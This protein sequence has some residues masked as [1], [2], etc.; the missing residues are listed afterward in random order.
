MPRADLN[1]VMCERERRKGGTIKGRHK[2]EKVKRGMQVRVHKGESTSPYSAKLGMKRP[3]INYT[4]DFSEN[5]NPL[6]GFLHKS[7]GRPWDKVYSEICQVFDKRKVI[8]QHILIHLFQNVEVNTFMHEGIVCTVSERSSRDNRVEPVTQSGSDY[9]VHP[10]SKL[11]LSTKPKAKLVKIAKQKEIE[12]EKAK[13]KYLHLLAR[14]ST[15][16]GNGARYAININDVWYEISVVETPKPVKHRRMNSSGE[17]E[18]VTHFPA[19]DAVSIHGATVI[20]QELRSGGKFYV[21][22]KDQLNKK[23]I[24]DL[25]LN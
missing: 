11:L 24:R 23:R 15:K 17:T 9:Y 1:K 13:A 18:Y 10:I 2:M 12:A 4:K 20:P 16:D 6:W 14:F 7:V 3:Y 21:C 19:V 5:L 22:R 25:G 8:N